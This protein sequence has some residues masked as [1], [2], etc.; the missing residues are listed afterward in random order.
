[1]VAGWQFETLHFWRLII[2]MGAE[3]LAKRIV[4]NYLEIWPSKSM[5]P[6]SILWNDELLSDQRLV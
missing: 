6:K 2:V 1:V 5:M 4:N 3:M